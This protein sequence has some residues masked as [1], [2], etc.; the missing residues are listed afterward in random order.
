MG[1]TM[2]NENI[3]ILFRNYIDQYDFLNNPENNEVYKW[4][5]IKH[6]SKIWKK[7]Y[8]DFAQKLKD[9]FAKSSNLINNRIV[10]PA[11]G[12][13]L[14]AQREPD[15]VREALDALLADDQNDIPARQKRA[16]TFVDTIN[17][18][19]DKHF[20]GKWKYEQ[21][22]RAAIAYLAMFDPDK[23]YLFKA[24]PAHHFA[25]Y[26][27]YDGD[28]GSGQTFSLQA[29][30]IMCDQLKERIKTSPEMLANAQKRLED[31]KALQNHTPGCDEHPG[32]WEDS[33]HHVLVYDLI[34]CMDAYN[35]TNGM[36][37]PVHKSKTTTAKQRAWRKEMEAALQADVDQLQDQIDALEAQINALPKH[38]FEGMTLKTKAFGVVTISRQDGAYLF[39]E[40]DGQTKQFAL[41]DCIANGFLIP[42]DTEVIQQ[43]KL[44]QS[45]NKQIN[46]LETQQKL[47][48][49]DLQTYQE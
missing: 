46:M 23:N 36:K 8:Q 14:L 9:A 15:K 24:T 12:L 30:Y 6:A 5:A 2:N 27:E 35:L 38:Q 34:Y 48:V 32:Q 13:V 47:K 39:F 19:L 29:Y 17:T 25:Q 4:Q 43:Y 28:I 22:M 42:Q 37:P 49:Y 20:H 11:H 33:K 40:V 16:L 44:E 1:G 3:S 31:W 26:M 41:P 21:D 10:Q 18:L 45:L 7:D